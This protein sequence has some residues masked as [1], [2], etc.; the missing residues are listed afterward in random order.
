MRS[1]HFNFF[2][3]IVLAAASP[4]FAADDLRATFGSGV[5]GEVGDIPPGTDLQR[6]TVN[7][8]AFPLARCNDNSPAIFYFRPASDAANA[9]RWIIHLQGGGSCGNGLNCSQ[10]RFSA[11]TN[12]GVK[13]MTSVDFPAG[14]TDNGIFE[15]STPY[16]A[17]N[18]FARYNQVFVHY[19]SSDT[20]TG[21]AED[22]VLTGL[23]FR[24]D[25]PIPRQY[26][27]S[28]LGR[29]IFD[30]VIETLRRNGVPPLVY[31]RPGGGSQ[32]MP[33]LD[34][35]EFVILS[36]GSAGGGGVIHNL[37]H[38]RGILPAA[39]RLVGLSDSAFR[40]SK[41]GMDL[42]QSPLCVNQGACTVDAQNEWIFNQGPY[43]VW[44]AQ[45]ASDRSC[46]LVPHQ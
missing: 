2:F 13:N 8:N 33:D 38:L 27:I 10:R 12:F 17:R 31:L 1:W 28:F 24:H 15:R 19:C 18:L 34:N 29:P 21:A 4:A 26:T 46:R 30:A 44:G 16:A 5:A 9:K 25:P 35:A 20:W 41:D 32:V 23:D 14:T 37:D 6:H 22:V 11:G 7:Q 36:G 43:A 40:P 39:T 3:L 42:S 45:N